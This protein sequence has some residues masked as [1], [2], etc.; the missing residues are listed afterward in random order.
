[1]I[2]VF[3][4]RIKNYLYDKEYLPVVRS[5]SFVIS[6]GNLTW[7]GTGK[8]SLALI[9]GSY[10]L[11]SG[12]RVAILSRGYGRRSSGFHIVDQTDG[13]NVFGDEPFLLA[14]R[15]PRALVAVCED[16]SR[17][18]ALLEKEH[19]DVILLDDA[20]QH[21]R[22]ARDL[23]V[24]LVDVSESIPDLKVLPFGKLREPVDSIHRSDAV[25]LTHTAHGR[26]KTVQWM[27][28]NV[29]VPVFHAD[30][31]PRDAAAWKG[32]KA[33]AFC[34]IGAPQH[35]FEML[36]D[37]E[38]RVVLRKSFPDHHAFTKKE[39]TVFQKQAEQAGAEILITTPKDAVRLSTDWFH[40]PLVVAEAELKIE[41]EQ[42]FRKFLTERLPKPVQV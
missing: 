12:Y 14:Q 25:I 34:G 23:D 6:I 10:L 31:D 3:W 18:I 30:Y 8:T 7:G 40:I 39:I 37:Q 24:I 2:G 9:I 5:R 21:R 27:R 36:S 1:M 28:D 22:V 26:K 15:L 4:S 41:E 13:W 17:G 11:E 33:A 16:R 19:P 32:K 38:V 29:R 20:F 35:F 42:S